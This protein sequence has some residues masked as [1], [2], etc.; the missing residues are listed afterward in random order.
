VF[1]LDFYSFISQVFSKTTEMPC[2]QA[3]TNGLQ[4]AWSCIGTHLTAEGGT[5]I[6]RSVSVYLSE[7]SVSCP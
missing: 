6:L 1:R 5:G 7:Y 4:T 3:K 2:L